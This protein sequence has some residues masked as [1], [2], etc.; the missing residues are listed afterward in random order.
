MLSVPL[1]LQEAIDFTD[2]KDFKLLWH[3]KIP[4]LAYCFALA[5]KGE[6]DII[7]TRRGCYDWDIAAVD[8]ILEELGQFIID[9]NGNKVRYGV[10]DYRHAHLFLYP[11]DCKKLIETLQT[12]LQTA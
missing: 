3:A 2:Y 1:K 4:S 5:V 8:L 11:K 9:N 12:Y 6:V 10:N 7:I